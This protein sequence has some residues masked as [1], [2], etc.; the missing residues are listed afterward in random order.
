[1][2]SL[3]YENEKKRD[4]CL[5]E[6]EAVGEYFFF[7]LVF[8]LYVAMLLLGCCLVNEAIK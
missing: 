4:F 3:K 8:T 1:M 6:A 2:H 5:T 7:F